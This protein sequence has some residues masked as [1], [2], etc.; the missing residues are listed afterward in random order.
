MYPDSEHIKSNSDTP[1]TRNSEER[2]NSD[3]ES[4]NAN[5]SD[6]SNLACSYPAPAKDRNLPIL[7]ALESDLVPI[8]LGL[9]SLTEHQFTIDALA[10]FHPHE[11]AWICT[12]TTQVFAVEE[13]LDIRDGAT[14]SF[15]QQHTFCMADHILK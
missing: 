11:I 8:L 5:P 1:L 10:H 3:P 9:C 15:G 12:A 4:F 7:N 2:S 6:A 14:A 13:A